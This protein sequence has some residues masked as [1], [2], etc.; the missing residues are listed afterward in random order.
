MLLRDLIAAGV[1][2]HAARRGH[3]L[4]VVGL[5]SLSALRVSR[6]L[7]DQ[8]PPPPPSPSSSSRFFSRRR[9]N[10]DVLSSTTSTTEDSDTI[11]DAKPPTSSSAVEPGHVYFVATP[12]GNLKDVTVRALEVLAAADVVC[13]EDTRHTVQLLRRLRLPR[14]ELLSHHEHNLP[15]AVPRIVALAQAGRSVA[16]VSDA[17]T[18]G[19]SDPGAE[20]AAALAA[21]GVPVHPVPGP[22]AVVAA[23]SIAGFPSTAFTFFGFLPVKGRERQEA[24]Q[25]VAA[26]DHPVVLYEAP[27]R[28]KAL[29]RQLRDAEVGLGGVSRPVVCC[30]ELTKLYEEVRRGTVAEVCAWLETFG[31]H[32]DVRA[33]PVCVFCRAHHP[34]SVALTS[35]RAKRESGASSHLCWGRCRRLRGIRSPMRPAPSTRCSLSSRLT[36]WRGQKRCGLLSMRYSYRNLPY[37]KSPC[38]WMI[39]SYYYCGSLA[40][41]LFL[42]GPPLFQSIPGRHRSILQQF[43]APPAGLSVSH[44]KKKAQKKCDE[45]NNNN[46]PRPS[47]MMALL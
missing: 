42:C 23:L 29:F 44:R 40:Y 28:V 31:D 37:T 25:R 32:D 26:T 35:H 16:V 22:S 14:K 15:A 2:F 10:K 9:S 19:I 41:Y 33:F 1:L 5:R 24:L 47:M 21:A 20:L 17:G 3:A 18:P 45:N 39:G 7:C 38:K 36:V 6:P 27:H 46:T 11:D 12:L 4:D 8:P 30:R 13:A 34:H 43:L